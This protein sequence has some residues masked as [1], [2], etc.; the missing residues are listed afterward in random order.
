MTPR[1]TDRYRFWASTDG[2]PM[3]GVSWCPLATSFGAQPTA[4]GPCAA[5]PVASVT[6]WRMMRRARSARGERVLIVGVGGGVS[7]A[8][9]M[10][11]LHLGAEVYVTSSSEAKHEWAIAH[12]ARG[13]CLSSGR[14]PSDMDV[15]VESVGPATWDS[16]CRA[17]RPG[18][19]MVVCG[20]TSG[21][22]AELN[23]PTLVL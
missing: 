17:L 3:V 6:A 7:T 22:V 8:A 13:A 14:F 1:S 2:E 12:G 23:L 4:P 5:L 20:G 15:V 18:G 11:A 19:R 9:M 21:S 16:S 10:V